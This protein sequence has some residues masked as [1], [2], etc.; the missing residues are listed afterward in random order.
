[1]T[2]WTQTISIIATVVATAYYIHREIQQDIRILSART[3]RLYEMYAETQKEINESRKEMKQLHID[4][5][6]KEKRQNG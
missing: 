2:D 1:M 6:T 5:I 4:F 3:D